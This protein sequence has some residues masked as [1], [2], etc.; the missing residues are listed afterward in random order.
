MGVCLSNHRLSMDENSGNVLHSNSR[1]SS[2]NL[3]HDHMQTPN[4]Q[5]TCDL[6]CSGWLICC[7]YCSNHIEPSAEFQLVILGPGYTGK[8]TLR[9]H[10]VQRY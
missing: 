7:P 9:H 5:C 1:K 10:L 4:H 8:T 3:E 6:Y 2:L